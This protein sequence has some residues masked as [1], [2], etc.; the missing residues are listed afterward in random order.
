M[1]KYSK[2]IAVAMAVL[3]IM[4]TS[5]TAFADYPVLTEG[6]LHGVNIVEAF[7]ETV[8]FVFTSDETAE[9]V[10]NSFYNEEDDDIDPFVTIYD[11]DGYEIANGDDTGLED[12]NFTV[13]FVAEAGQVYYIELASFLGDDS[14]DIMIEACDEH[15]ECFDNDYDAY[16]DWCDELLCDHICH[17]GGITGFFW[18]I[19]NFFN[20]L[21]FIN[22][23]C[24]CGAWHY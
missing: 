18:K 3:M 17:K 2:I 7:E 6:E 23:F 15:T 13:R 16:C 10:L 21:F 14:F 5:I 8:T 20:S 1:K 4:M 11:E 9:Y 22:P 12:L 19:I 24:E